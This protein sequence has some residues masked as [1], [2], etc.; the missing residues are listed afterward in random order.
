IQAP[1]LILGWTPAEYADQLADYKLAQSV[2]DEDYAI[3]LNEAAKATGK[4][5]DIHAKLDTGMSRTGIFAQEDPKAAAQIVDRISKLSNLNMKGI[6]THFAAA[7]MPEKDDFTAWQLSNYNAVLAELEALGFDK[8]VV[9]HTGNSAGIMY[10]PET[11]CD[12]VRMGVMMYGLYPDGKF[13]PDGPLEPALTLKARVAQV[14]ELPAGAHISYGCTAKTERPTKIAVV[15]AGYADAYS[16]SLSNKGA[17]AVINGCKCPQIG[18]ICMDMC[19]FDVTDADVHRGDEVI[20]YGRGGMPMEE[21]AAL[22]GSI[23]CEPLC[24][25]TNRVKKV[26]V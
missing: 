25:L 21:V 23:N 9:H 3:E 1:I 26:Y 24:L 2:I 20:L 4:T 16:R 12:M 10:H 19:M 14:K 17:Y 6:F 11:H 13:Q 15:S 22:A 8:D 5:V 18:R 7:D